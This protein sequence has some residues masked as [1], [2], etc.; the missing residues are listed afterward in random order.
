M[1]VEQKQSKAIVQFHSE[2]NSIGKV[3]KRIEMAHSVV[4]IQFKQDSVTPSNPTNQYKTNN[5][6]HFYFHFFC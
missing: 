4:H 6:N 2:K 5:S 1:F 3:K